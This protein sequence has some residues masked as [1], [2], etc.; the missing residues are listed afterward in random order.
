MFSFHGLDWVYIAHRETSREKAGTSL[1][2]SS[3]VVLVNDRFRFGSMMSAISFVFTTFIGCHSLRSRYDDQNPFHLGRKLYPSGY[4]KFFEVECFMLTLALTAYLL[5]GISSTLVP[6]NENMN[7]LI[8]SR[9]AELERTKDEAIQARKD[10]EKALDVAIS[11][12]AT[13]TAFLSAMSHEIRTPMN[14]VIAVSEL[15][16]DTELS[17]EQAEYVQRILLS[18]AHLLGMCYTLMLSFL[19]NEKLILLFL[20]LCIFSF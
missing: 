19:L 9:T 11:A 4:L 14:G 3:Y 1:F 16:R 20:S 8:T 13:K 5:S 12:T 10:A 17:E 18:S 6:L 7:R 2:L 15:L